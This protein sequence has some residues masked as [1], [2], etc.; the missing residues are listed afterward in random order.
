[1]HQCKITKKIKY[2][3]DT[4]DQTI[5]FVMMLKTHIT[6]IASKMIQLTNLIL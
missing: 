3:K 4:Y 2:K 5:D 6:T 1:V